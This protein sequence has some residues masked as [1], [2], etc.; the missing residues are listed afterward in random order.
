M[1]RHVGVHIFQHCHADGAIP[2]EG[3]RCLW[4]DCDCSYSTVGELWHHVV[5]HVL[6]EHTVKVES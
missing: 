2:P 1:N 3:H 5:D 6:E 4:V